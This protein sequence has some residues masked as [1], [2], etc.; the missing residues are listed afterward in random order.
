MPYFLRSS[1]RTS[2]A[3]AQV[4]VSE[5]SPMRTAVGS[6]LLA[7]PMAEMTFMPR[8]WA[9]AIRCSLAVTLSIA[10]TT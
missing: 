1:L 2:R 6:S 8:A 3:R 9:E 7:A 4:C 10:S 5:M